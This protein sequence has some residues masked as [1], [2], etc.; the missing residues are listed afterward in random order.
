MNK[1]SIYH[2][3]FREV[4]RIPFAYQVIV[5]GDT[6]NKLGVCGNIVEESQLGHFTRTVKWSNPEFAKKW[7]G[8]LKDN[9]R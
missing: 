7:V 3:E 4:R 2:D 6:E 9:R 8:D 1:I 5:V